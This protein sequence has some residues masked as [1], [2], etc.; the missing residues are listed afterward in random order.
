MW[1]HPAKVWLREF[2][3]L[4]FRALQQHPECSTC[5][6]HKA[7]IQ[8]LGR[9]V[10]ARKAQQEAYFAHLHSQYLDRLE[11]W[12]HRGVSR[13]RTAELTLICDGMDQS[14]FFYPRA[15]SLRAKEFAN[16]MRPK[17]HVI[18]CL[19]HGYAVH[20]AV[21]EPDLPK[22]ASTHIEF[23][24]YSLTKLEQQGVVLRD[25]GVR[26]QCDNTTRDCK[27]NVML[28]FLCA[29]VSKCNLDCFSVLLVRSAFVVQALKR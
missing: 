27:S 25:L 5:V 23:L 21:T 7:L 15:A 4:K 20:F 1:V 16:F 6:R 26:L 13:L 28:A 9:H 24:A 10:N 2:P 12:S 17:A 3:F 22:D 19:L 18:G 29:L 14:K 11:Y 8:N